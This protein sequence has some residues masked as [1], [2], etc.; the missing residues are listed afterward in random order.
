MNSF[1]EITIMN[2]LSTK[3]VEISNQLDHNDGH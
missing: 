3:L 1:E 2:A